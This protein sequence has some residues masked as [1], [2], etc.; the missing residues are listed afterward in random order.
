M[1][2]LG[3][4]R[5]RSSALPAQDHRAPTASAKTSPDE[6]ILWRGLGFLGITIPDSSDSMSPELAIVPVLPIVYLHADMRPDVRD[7][8][9]I[10]QAEGDGE[11]VSQWLIAEDR[12]H[13]RCIDLLVEV[14]RPVE[15]Q[16]RVAF[17]L[18]NETV[19]FWLEVANRVERIAVSAETAAEVQARETAA[20]G[21]W[22]EAEALLVDVPPPFDLLAQFYR[23]S[24]IDNIRRA[25][26]GPTRA[27]DT[28]D[29]NDQHLR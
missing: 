15:C 29:C 27:D 26:L 11:I 14:H 10:H 19:W 6:P 21:A 22:R 12:A 5:R 17:S 2:W 9:R 25:H 24:D 8:A 16:F 20:S 4:L 1:R 23:T 28:G 7:L 18:D 3:W 13:N